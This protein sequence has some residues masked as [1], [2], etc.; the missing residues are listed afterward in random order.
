MDWE[1]CTQ[2]GRNLFWSRSKFL[3]PKFSFLKNFT[4]V[5]EFFQSKLLTIFVNDLFLDNNLMLTTSP[6]VG[7]RKLWQQFTQHL[8]AGFQYS[9]ECTW[10][11]QRWCLSRSRSRRLPQTQA[12]G[13]GRSCNMNLQLWMTNSQWQLRHTLTHYSVRILSPGTTPFVAMALM[14]MAVS[15]VWEKQHE[16]RKVKHS[17]T[18]N[19]QTLML[20]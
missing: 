16:R 19:R 5:M 1:D 13:S 15:I 20:C 14:E 17:K 11:L 2:T 8:P 7:I 18:A 9:R 4:P 3:D 10:H 6:L 12:P